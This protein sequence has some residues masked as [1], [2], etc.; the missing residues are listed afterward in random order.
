VRQHTINK[1]SYIKTTKNQQD[2]IIH[3]PI[4]TE[5]CN[6]DDMESTKTKRSLFE[7]SKDNKPKHNKGEK[8]INL[9]LA[10][11]SCTSHPASEY[12]PRTAMLG[13]DVK[14]PPN[15]LEPYTKPGKP[16]DN[17]VMAMRDHN[18]MMGE[19]HYEEDDRLLL[20]RRG[21]KFDPGP[22]TI[23]EGLGPAVYRIWSQKTR[24]AQYERLG[25]TVGETSKWVE[26]D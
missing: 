25:L 18:T 10:T 20:I 21:S 19:R 24:R 15:L 7:S 13:H 3:Q 22:F 12:G 17:F 8:N 14:L 23:T 16:P 5:D 11:N 1:V 9:Q 2:H 26:T 6:P 4:Q